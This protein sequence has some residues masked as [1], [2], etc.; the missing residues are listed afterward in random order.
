M[1]TLEHVGKAMYSLAKGIVAGPSS[2]A[3]AYRSEMY[4]V[5]HQFVYETGKDES[6]RNLGHIVSGA[7]GIAIVFTDHIATLDNYQVLP[8]PLST[9]L[10]VTN[11]ASFVFEMGKSIFHKN[12]PVS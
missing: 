7:L 9:A 5:H 1:N 4:S 3:N 8:E 6:L 2:I 10:L 12:T 11:G